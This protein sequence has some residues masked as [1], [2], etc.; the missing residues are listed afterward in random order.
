VAKIVRKHPSNLE[1]KILRAK[2]KRVYKE[3][4][5]L[6]EVA[7]RCNISTFIAKQLLHDVKPL[8]IP[9]RDAVDKL[10]QKG[11]SKNELARQLAQRTACNTGTAAMWFRKLHTPSLQIQKSIVQLNEEL[12]ALVSNLNIPWEEAIDEL[13]QKGYTR[14]SLCRELCQIIKCSVGA[15]Q[16]WFAKLRTPPLQIQEAIVRLNQDLPARENIPWELAVDELLKRGYSQAELARQLSQRIKCHTDVA[17]KWLA[18]QRV[19]SLKIQKAIVS[20]ALELPVIV[21]DSD[22]WDKSIDDL[23]QKG[24]SKS[25]LAR[26]LCEII[27]CNIWTAQKWFGKQAV[28]PFQ[29]QAAIIRLN[30]ML[31]PLVSSLNIPWKDAIE[32]LL[33]K[34]YARNELARQLCQRIGCNVGTAIDWFGKRATPSFQ[35]QEAI[36]N[37]N[38]E[39][40]KLKKK[41]IRRNNP[42]LEDKVLRAKAKHIY[43]KTGS[44]T[45]VARQLSINIHHAKQLVQD[46][47]LPEIS[48]KAAVDE[49]LYKGYSKSELA[50]QLHQR[51]AFPIK[52]A[53]SWFAKLV[54]PS[55]QIQ[56][57]IVRLNKELPALV[58]RMDIPWEE[59][60]D[61]LFQ[62]GYHQ[63][64]L[65]R[66]LCQRI[67][68]N[69]R[70]AVFWFS[71]TYT[72][73]L[74]I[75]EAIVRLNEELPALISRVDIPWE[76]AVD[77]LLQK[78]YSQSELARALRDK[79]KCKVGTALQ[80]IRKR[81]IPSLQTQEVIVSLNQELPVLVS[82]LDI[83]WEEAVDKLRQKGYRKKEL[84]RQ[85]CQRIK[86]K[87][88]T[89]QNWFAKRVTPSIRIQ[90]AI[91]K[92]NKELPAIVSNL[93]LWEKSVD[94]LL[95]KGYSKSELARQLCKI[96]GCKISTAQ[97]WF[98][99]QNAPPFQIQATI[100]KLNKKLP[101]LKKKIIKRHNP[102]LEDKFLRAKARNLY[103]KGYSIVQI[104]KKLEIDRKTISLWVV[105]IAFNWKNAVD[106]LLAKGYKI[107]ELAHILAK[108]IKC[109]SGTAKTWFQKTRTPKLDVQT[110]IVK[111]NQLLPAKTTWEQA[112]DE[113]LTKGYTRLELAS[114]LCE[115]YLNCRPKTAQYWFSQKPQKK[116]MRRRLPST[117][118]RN[119]IIKLNKKLKAKPWVRPGDQ[120]WEQAVNELIAKGYSRSELGRI[121]AKKIKYHP[122][123]CATFFRKRHTPTLK[124]QAEIIKLNKLLPSK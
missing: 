109:R 80:W 104:S 99:K 23:L 66:Q 49:L 96:V 86:C 63:N 57:A 106:Q 119:A 7:R 30:R 31:P 40:P 58:S 39:L 5:N 79:I 44:F 9:W 60:V 107:M 29:A 75:Q 71:R 103:S 33:Q 108:K 35:I 76:E 61:K 14:S 91:V 124:V 2:V 81:S 17:R 83:P 43:T 111:L 19:P 68:C 67:K 110:E 16:N 25:E 94:A 28:P 36:V 32:D 11:Y 26:Q 47:D 55:I 27:E 8:E 10:L 4:G 70:T 13:L 54:I 78:G 41:I 118:A 45:A 64:E 114:L 100:I 3:T 101:K 53:W 52:T 18:K 84:A 37:L 20:L 65:A 51:I 85:L 105:D 24:Y 82:S 88:Q 22:L 12:P 38:K 90:E 122:I 92:L 73:S 15:A 62:K 46:I 56:E 1:E 102:G 113:L 59:A 93:D 69:V 87:V 116:T 112:V 72:P 97:K 89:A 117:E 98:R 6:N 21:P 115:K 120:T 121:L 50:R 74:Q 123:A 34:G 95:Q 48:W 77:K 42:G